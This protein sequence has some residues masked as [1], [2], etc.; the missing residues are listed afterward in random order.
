MANEMEQYRIAVQ[1]YARDGVNYLFHNKGDEHALIILSNIFKNAKSHIRIAANKLYNDEVVNT[2]EYV[3]SMK[4]FLDKKDT[5]LDILITTKP[6]KEE[7]TEYGPENTLYWMLYNHPAYRQGRVE[8]KEGQGRF[9][10][11]EEGV[12]VDFC[13]GDEKMFRLEG[14]IV[15]RQAIANFNDEDATRQLIEAFDKVY[16]SLTSKVE[17][18]DYYAK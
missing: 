3:E 16:P 9:F 7:V 11:N 14:D 4:A 5:R 10:R 17:L 6:T 18:K 13:T 12:Q 1:N 2:I 15:K 8:I